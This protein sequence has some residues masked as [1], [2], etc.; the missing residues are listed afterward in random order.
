MNIYGNNRQIVL[1]LCSYS[2]MNGTLQ[3]A[4]LLLDVFLISGSLFGLC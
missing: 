2:N 1:K 4:Q 3:C